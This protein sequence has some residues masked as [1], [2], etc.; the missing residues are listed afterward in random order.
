M[1]TERAKTR[2]GVT[3]FD[4]ELGILRFVYTQGAECTLAD[5][6]ENV[7]VQLRLTGGKVVPI[8]IDVS[9]VKSV[10]KAARSYYGESKTVRALALIGG[11]PIGNIIGNVFL[12]VHGARETPTKFF[13]SEAEAIQ[14]LRGFVDRGFGGGAGLPPEPPSVD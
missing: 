3:W 13:G 9:A 1:A 4:E 6:K 8:L 12:A 10:D 11:S 5:A 2:T 7:E 14:W